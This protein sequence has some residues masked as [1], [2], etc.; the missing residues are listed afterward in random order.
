MQTCSE[1]F[2]NEFYKEIVLQAKNYSG[3]CLDEFKRRAN[4]FPL[5]QKAIEEV[6]KYFEH[7]VNLRKTSICSMDVQGYRQ[8]RRLYARRFS[9][10]VSMGAEKLSLFAQIC[11]KY[12]LIYGKSWRIY[13]QGTLGESSPLQGYPSS[14]EMPRLELI[15]PEDM[16]A[17]R[18]YASAQI[19]ALSIEADSGEKE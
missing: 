16:A 10:E 5:L 15:N 6:N 2:Q 14:F 7:L 4:D 1:E 3:L 12:S 18:F 9:N 13:G 19:V 17:R 8:A 11:K